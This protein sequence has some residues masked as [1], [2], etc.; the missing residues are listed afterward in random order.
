MHWLKTDSMKKS[1][2][3][4]FMMLVCKSY[5]QNTNNL[6][7]SLAANNPV[8]AEQTDSL[9]AN[10]AEG[11]HDQNS[12]R[13][14]FLVTASRKMQLSGFASI[15]YQAFDEKN[16]DDGM[17]IRRARLGLSGE[18]TPSLTYRFQTEFADRPKLLDAYAELRI[19]DYFDIMVG[20]FKVP[21]SFESL[22]SL[23]QFELIDFCQAVDAMVS[24]TRDVIGNQNGRDIGIQLGGSLLKKG[25]NI[26]VEYR[27]AV[28]NG[29]GINVA[30]TANKAKDIVGRLIVNPV[31]GLSLGASYYNGWGKAID[32]GVKYAGRSQPRNR[33][34][35]DMEYTGTRLSMRTEY[36]QG[37]DGETEKEGWYAFAGYYILPQ[38]LQLVFKYDIY[39]PDRSVD[40]DVQ[41]LYV[42]GANYQFNP[43]SRIQAC[44]TFHEEEGPAVSNNYFSV[45]Y[46]IGL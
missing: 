16:E 22:V 20:Q 18:I 26:L 2:L 8:T 9:R 44:Y 33:F 37:T 6:P 30:D 32:P 11:Q 21:F 23:R 41:T 5:A 35:F 34:G 15:R 24:R 19:N 14:S 1:I 17:D 40:L 12:G 39:D 31:K 36:L 10:T 46:F 45:Q 27:I 43:W 3:G 7:D 42:A 28:L 25:S 4:V 29:S 13:K 38:K